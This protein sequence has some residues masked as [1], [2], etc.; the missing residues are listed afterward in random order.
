MTDNADSSATPDWKTL[1]TKAMRTRAGF[2]AL[3]L[4]MEPAIQNIA[5][6]YCPSDPEGAAQEARMRL[7]RF[8]FQQKRVDLSYPSN[9][10]GVCLRTIA[11]NRIM[12]EWSSVARNGM[13]GRGRGGE[14]GPAKKGVARPAPRPEIVPL[15]HYAALSRAISN[16]E[17]DTLPFPLSL[18]AQFYDEHGTL[19]GAAAWC[20]ERFGYDKKKVDAAYKRVVAIMKR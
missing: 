6:Q 5:R 8:V 10:I 13:N 20:E 3:L 1:A 12:K 19:V 15:E 18:Y 9:T 14:T 16:E 4:A 17:V 11:R 7:F 2:E